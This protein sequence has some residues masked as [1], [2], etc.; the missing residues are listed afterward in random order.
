MYNPAFST[1]AIRGPGIEGGMNRMK[2]QKE[3]RIGGEKDEK[4]GNDRKN[5]R[6][7]VEEHGGWIGEREKK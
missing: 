5:K 2:G 1:Q 4:R 7:N 6:R 3:E